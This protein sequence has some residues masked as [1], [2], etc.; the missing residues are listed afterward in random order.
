L[1]KR[2]PLAVTLAIK[3]ENMSFEYYGPSM[4]IEEEI[5]P[6]DLHCPL[7]GGGLNF[8]KEKCLARQR[9]P[10]DSTCY[11]GCRGIR[12]NSM[13]KKNK[14]N[15]AKKTGNRAAAMLMLKHNV[16]VSEIAKA[17]NVSKA[18]VYKYKGGRNGK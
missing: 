2:C 15:G 3:R 13:A 18:T 11:G 5:R 8:Y 14:L 10:Q 4:A 9:N 6:F 1:I 7:M 17:L 16:P 12:V